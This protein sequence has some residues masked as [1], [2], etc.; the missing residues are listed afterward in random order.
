MRNA[1]I[2]AC[3]N[4]NPFSFSVRKKVGG[5][6]EAVL[7]GCNWGDPIVFLFQNEKVVKDRGTFMQAV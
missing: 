2:S 1:P 4:K 7:W 3:A 6:D 5:R